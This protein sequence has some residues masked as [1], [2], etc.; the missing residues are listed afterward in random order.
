MARNIPASI[1][2]CSYGTRRAVVATGLKAVLLQRYIGYRCWELMD[3]DG[4]TRYMVALN[5]GTWSLIA[6]DHR[7]PDWRTTRGHIRELMQS[8][9][10]NMSDDT[11][12]CYDWSNE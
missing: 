4:A 7:V 6:W 11:T 1:T 8:D 9:G 3:N 10:C 5:S 2:S 12:R